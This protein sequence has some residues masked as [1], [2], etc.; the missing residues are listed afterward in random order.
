M[1]EIQASHGRCHFVQAV[2]FPRVAAEVGG[3]IAG[4]KSGG[5]AGDAV[6][7]VPFKHG[8]LARRQLVEQIACQEGPKFPIDTSRIRSDDEKLL[9]GTYVHCLNLAGCSRGRSETD[10]WISQ[11]AEQP[12]GGTIFNRSEPMRGFATVTVQAMEKIG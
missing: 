8:F 7:S 12:G 9:L 10:L 6:A 3:K 11:A 1:A 2:Q 4:V 5:V